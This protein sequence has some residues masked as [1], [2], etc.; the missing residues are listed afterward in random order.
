[1]TKN[2][3]HFTTKLFWA[4]IAVYS[5]FGLHTGCSSYRRALKREHPALQNMKI[6]DFFLFLRVVFALLDPDLATQI[7][8]DPDPKPRYKQCSRSAWICIDIKYFGSPRPDSDNKK[9]NFLTL[10]LVPK[11]SNRVLYPSRYSG[12]IKYNSRN[13]YSG[14]HFVDKT[15]HKK[16]L[17]DFCIQ[18]TE[19]RNEDAPRWDGVHSQTKTLNMYQY[20]TQ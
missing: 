10:I 16:Y 4:K 5:S 8:A 3:K 2:L 18:V 1:M 15:R 17:F 12:C 7:N 13:K 14:N 11:F 19:Q 20:S 6:L 9:F